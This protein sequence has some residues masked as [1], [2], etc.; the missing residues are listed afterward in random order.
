MFRP[1]TLSHVLESAAKT[2][3]AVIVTGRQLIPIEARLTATPS[4]RDAAAIEAFQALFGK[5]AGTG[6]VVCLCSERTPLGRTVDARPR[7]GL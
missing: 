6:F 4:A 5:R 1:R 3:P 2:F 7:G